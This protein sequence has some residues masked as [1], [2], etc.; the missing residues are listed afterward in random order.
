VNE[1]KKIALLIPNLG[2]GGAERLVVDFANELADLNYR[3]DLVVVNAH[4]VYKSQVS[5][6]V[7]LID[8][9]AKRVLFAIF[10]L[11]SYFK[12]QK[13]DVIYSALFHMNLAALMA[14]FLLLSNTKIIVSIHNTLSILLKNINSIMAKI[15]IFL[16]RFFYPRAFEIIAVSKGVADDLKKIIPKCDNIVVIYNAAISKEKLD[17]S[18][19]NF[20]HVWITAKNYPVILT[21]GRLTAQKNYSMLLHS[22]AK[23]KS[24]LPA[25]LIILGEGELR[26]KL[27]QEI[28]QLN[29]AEDVDMPGFVNNPYPYL[30][31]CDLFV[32]TSNYEG[33]GI[34]LVEAL[35][36][37]TK[38]A[39][40]DCMSGP[41]EILCDGK[42]G[43]LVKVGDVDG[44][45]YA[46]EKSLRSTPVVV[47]SDHLQKF[48]IEK[49][50]QQHLDI[51]F[52]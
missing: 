49:F 21:I 1:R 9:K 34:V 22:F 44:M 38:V 23:L 37:G 40:T 27:Q 11:R 13:P 39:A 51:F 48:S 6:K 8:L 20:D 47:D 31:N 4:G 52:K 45:A 35:A 15:F 29:L 32:L 19:E 10:K 18:L 16:M 25:K 24:N 50:V 41:R 3:V 43:E 14:N 7:N 17:K 36:L 12:H 2:G 33:F 42:Y 5:S 28:C 26:S 46:M 30:K